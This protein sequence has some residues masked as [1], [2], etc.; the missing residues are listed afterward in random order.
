MAETQVI[1]LVF[2]GDLA[3]SLN[4]SEETGTCVLIWDASVASRSL[5]HCATMLVS[6]CFLKIVCV[7]V[8]I[9]VL[10]KVPEVVA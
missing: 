9:L 6:L 2:P 7:S 8:L 4:E 1:R 3:G 5:T 10:S